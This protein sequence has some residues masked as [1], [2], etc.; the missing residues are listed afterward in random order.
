MVSNW[1][2]M[3][4]SQNYRRGP[5]FKFKILWPSTLVYFSFLTIFCCLKQLWTDFKFLKNSSSFSIFSMKPRPIFE[6][7]AFSIFIIFANLFIYSIHSLLILNGKCLAK[8]VTVQQPDLDTPWLNLV[9]SIISCSEVLKT[10]RTARS[11]QTV[12]SI[13]WKWVQV[14]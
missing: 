7:L 2:S 13:S 9:S 6:N 8:K 10:P 14:S 12:T 4:N 5:I 11:C 1:L 3:K